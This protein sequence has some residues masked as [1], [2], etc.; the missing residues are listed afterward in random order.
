MK[1]RPLKLRKT[2]RSRKFP[3]PPKLPPIPPGWIGGFSKSN[4]AFAYPKPNLSSLQLEHNMAHL[5]LLKRQQG[6]RWPE[7][8]W[9]IIKG[10]KSTRCFQ[11][12][13]PF[14][15]RLGYT[16]TGQVYSI[17]CPQQGVWIFD[18]VC[19]NVEVTVTGVRGW[20]DESSDPKKRVLAADMTVKPRVWLTPSEHQ[21]N[22][23]KMAWPILEALFPELPLSKKQAILINTYRPK[24]KQKIADFPVRKGETDLFESPP[25]AKHYNKRGFYTV[26]NLGV[27]IGNIVERN[28]V[29][30]DDFNKLLMDGFNLGSGNMLSPTN[31]LTWN[32]WFTEPQKVDQQEW[33]DHAVKWR[34]SIDAHHGPPYTKEEIEEW[35][36]L[37]DP[38]PVRYFDGRVFHATDAFEDDLKYWL[39]QFYKWIEHHIGIHL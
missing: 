5:K 3:K 15:S 35:P 34:D 13:S 11:M 6:V 25:F 29:L 16:N 12:F 22:K 17:I 1:K 10:K 4:P 9:E 28:N 7:F 2:R 36:H 19:L 33:K 39:E 32:V 21:G 38:R 24:T 37:F 27:E 8:S 14:I 26:G 20:V 30:V 23:L 31:V 18:E